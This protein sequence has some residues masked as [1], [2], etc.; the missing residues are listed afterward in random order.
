MKLVE[1]LTAETIVTDLK[2]QTKREVLVEMCEVLRNAGRI[3]DLDSVM[4]ILMEREALGSTG[5]GQ[6]IAI[7]H[8]KSDAIKEQIVAVGISKRGVDFDALDGEPVYILF[9]LL[10]PVEEAGAHLKALAKIS[11]LLK[12][13]YFR[14]ALRDAKTPDVL[15]KAIQD[16]D[17]Y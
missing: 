9:L 2:A 4:N 5:I 13:K 14:Q 10:A 8:A 12:D 1:L 3:S 17:E 7:P 15:L 6:G 16:E 11:R